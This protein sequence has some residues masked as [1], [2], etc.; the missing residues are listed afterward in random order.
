MHRAGDL[1]AFERA[2]RAE[3]PYVAAI[4]GRLAVPP[5]TVSDAVQD[6][7]IAAYRRWPDFDRDRPVRPWL[8]GFARH[9]A[10]RYRRSAARR[11]RKGAALAVVTRDRERPPIHQVAARDFL[12]RF[13]DAQEP[14]HRR[15]FV[16]AELEGRTA[17]E[18]ADALSIS[19]E[20][21]YG[22][23]RATRRRLKQALMLDA[24]QPSR[25]AAAIVPPWA[26]LLPRLSETVAPA[27]IAGLASAGAIKA[28]AATAVVGVGVLLAAASVRD[29]PQPATRLPAQHVERPR[30]PTEP[31]PSRRAPPAAPLPAPVASPAVLDAATPST[32]S[33]PAAVP[34]T[35]P[36]PAPVSPSHTLADETALLQSAKAASTR[37][38]PEAALVFLREHAV[39]YPDG[40]L[41]DARRRA[42]IR[43]LC[44]L[45]RGAQARGEAQQMARARPGD[46]L[47]VQAISICNR[48]SDPD[49][50]PSGEGQK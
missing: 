28:F 13:L 2:Y 4:L 11:S 8:T 31:A 10:F 44:D 9:V 21:V 39:T 12:Q 33:V 38:D 34:T 19:V 23:V 41:S 46:P 5:D 1:Q 18:V 24:R 45:G 27:P 36:V 15:A 26:V 16:L 22:R 14:G 20:A 3:G 29:D 42:R 6:V 30:P 49:V 32:P 40:Q 43:A 48:P 47:A 50:A 17:P 37:G 35:V 25:R 7:F